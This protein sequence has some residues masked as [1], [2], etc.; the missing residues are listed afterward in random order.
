MQLCGELGIGGSDES[1]L[2]ALT[3]LRRA[4]A[5]KGVFSI[6]EL[7]KSFVLT[8]PKALSRWETTL[9]TYREASALYDVFETTR[10]KLGVLELVPALADR[11]E[12]AG[13]DAT[14]KRRLIDETHGPSR[15][16]VWLAEK[17]G[18]WVSGEVDRVT[19]EK[20]A[21]SESRRRAA[22]DDTAAFRAREQ[23]LARIGD[24]GG[25]P[26]SRSASSWRPPSATSP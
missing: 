6:D 15:L 23:A 20:R 12:I 26:P 10:K 22:D 5:S 4:Q 13:H 14:E 1:Q 3:L 21:L 7:F 24:L 18:S 9:G 11:Y 16:R 25:D 8:Q 17:V 2:K 19:T